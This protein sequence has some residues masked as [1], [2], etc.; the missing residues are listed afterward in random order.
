[1]L[2]LDRNA[3]NIAISAARSWIFNEVLS[4]RVAQGR[5]DVPML[6]DALQLNGSQSFFLHDGSDSTIIDRMERHDIHTTGPLWGQGEPP[7]LGEALAFESAAVND[8]PKLPTGLA[9]FGLK[10]Q[11]RS[12][13]VLPENLTWSLHRPDSPD[14]SATLAFT[15]P[16][17]CF[18]TSVLRELIAAPGQ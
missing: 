11:R 12:L 13:R 15:L 4:G 5:W 2:K 10:Q 9:G 6:G 8:I 1:M 3:K 7:I 14:F 16:K 17:G 18:G